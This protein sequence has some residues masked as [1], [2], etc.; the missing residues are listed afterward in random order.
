[1]G[2]TWNLAGARPLFAQ[3]TQYWPKADPHAAYAA[4]WADPIA[5]KLKRYRAGLAGGKKRKR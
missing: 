2:N 5:A 3:L 1:V 4:A